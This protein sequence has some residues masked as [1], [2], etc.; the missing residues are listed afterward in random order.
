MA[1]GI[2]VI[3]LARELLVTSLRGASES[4]GQNFGAAFSGKLKMVFQSATILVILIYVNYFSHS[5][6]TGWEPTAQIVRDVFIWGTVA[7]T[8][9]SGLLYIQRAI[10][11]YQGARKA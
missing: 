10:A 9:I 7:I 2:V 5:L 1:P 8:V 11:L 4:E 6:G 3:L